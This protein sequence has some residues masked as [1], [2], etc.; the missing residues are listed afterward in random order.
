VD[1]GLS[2]TGLAPGEGI[3]VLTGLSSGF[4]LD[5]ASAAGAYPLAVAG[6]L[7]N[8]NYRLAARQD[9]TFTI[10]RRPATITPDALARVYGEANPTSGRAR[11]D[12]FVNGDGVVGVGLRS[13]ADARSG[14]G[15]YDLAAA[16][17]VGTGLAN[18]AI[19]YAPRSGG[20]TVTP[21][22][23]TLAGTRAYDATAAIAGGLLT[24]TDRV[25]ADV[26]TLSGTGRLAGRDVGTQ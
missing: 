1:P 11:G 20:L 6:T 21:R 23:V 10:A 9:G 14:V 4:A 18:Y 15:T 25:G 17:A 16:D 8:P 22:P 24:V 7:A 12:G 2:A 13:P 26:V 19:T 3:G 5:A